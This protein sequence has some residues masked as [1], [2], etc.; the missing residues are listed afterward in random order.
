[1]NT[2]RPLLQPETAQAIVDRFQPGYV[3][4]GVAVRTGGEV[5]T[6][7]EIRGDGSARPF[8]VKIYAS[9]WRPKLLKEVYVYRLLARHGI[10]HIPRVLHA[11]PSGLPELPLAYTVMTRLPGRP[12]SEVGDDLAG[13]DLVG[14]YRQMGQFLAAVHRISQDHWGYVTTRV[15]DVRPT[16][17]AYMTDQF[18]RKLRAFGDLGGDPALARAIERHVARHAGVFAACPR[19]VLCHNDFHDG[20]VLVS[21]STGTVADDSH[22]TLREWR[23]TGVVDVEGAVAADPLFDLARTDYYALR[24]NPTKRAAFMSGYG[25]LPPDSADRVAIYGLHHALE[26]WNWAASTGKP[27]DRSRARTDLERSVIDTCCPSTSSGQGKPARAKGERKRGS[28]G[29]GGHRDRRWPGA[30]LSLRQCARR[31]RRRRRGQ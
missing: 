1:V 14:V 4:T 17:T 28:Q 27:E 2:D 9:Q 25:P 31:G 6:V 13:P 21:R 7:Y 22:D 12:L 11:A 8:I 18:A 30:G 20:N 23:V 19:P 26:L 24:D 15:V 5:S 10:R 29:S 3:V 16:N